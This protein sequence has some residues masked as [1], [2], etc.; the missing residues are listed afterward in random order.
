MNT[1]ASPRDHGDATLA[2]SSPA[3]LGD[4]AGLAMKLRQFVGPQTPETQVDEIEIGVV[5]ALTNVVKHAYAGRAGSLE[6]RCEHQTE[7]IVIE[8]I[9][10]G[11]ALPA[12]RLEGADGTV[13]QFDPE[14]VEN[15][16]QGG[17]GLALIRASFDEVQYDSEPG[18]NRLTLVKHVRK[19]SA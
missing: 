11:D 7:R 9:D 2:L 1:P 18:C 12:G 3:T 16:P 14:D 17:M 13:F 10:H 5:E 8:L 4:V 19:A 15:I 6:L